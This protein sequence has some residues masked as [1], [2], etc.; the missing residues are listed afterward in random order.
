MGNGVL[1]AF[2]HATTA[3]YQV[4]LP[5]WRSGNHHNIGSV[6]RQERLQRVSSLDVVLERLQ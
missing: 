1:V 5:I 4:G 3:Y 2:S 6:V